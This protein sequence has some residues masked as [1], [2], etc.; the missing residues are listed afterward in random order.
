MHTTTFTEFR[1]QAAGFIDLVEQGEEIIIT[2]H[3]KPVAKIIPIF[4]KKRKEPSW[5]SKA[6]RLDIKGIS[7]SSAILE[8]REKE[9]A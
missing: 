7:L 3:N 4:L 6:L 2:R 5:R 8:E 9:N 1:N